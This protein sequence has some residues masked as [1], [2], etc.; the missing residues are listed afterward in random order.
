MTINLN[1]E[2]PAPGPL[3]RVAR[4][5]GWHVPAAGA[6]PATIE[7]WVG[8]VPVGGTLRSVRPD[9]AAAFA[10]RDPRLDCGFVGDLVF[11]R[12]LADGAT[13]DV[14][15]QLTAADGTSVPAWQ[16]SFT[17]AE[18]WSPPAPR[19]RDY[20]L[21]ALL[22]RPGTVSPIHFDDEAE[23][24]WAG[25]LRVP[26]IA[27]VPHF[28][29][30]RA[31]PCVRLLD[32]GATHPYGPRSLALIEAGGTVLDLGCGI[33]SAEQ[34][35]PNV[36]HLDAIHFPNVDVVNTCADLPFHD[37][38]FDT[39]VSQAVFE[40]LPDPAHTAAEILRVLKPGGRVLIETGFMVP[41]HGDPDHY[42]NMTASAMRRVMRGFEIES[43]DVPDYQNPSWGLRMQLEAALLSMQPGVWRKRLELWLAELQQGGAA[44]DRDLGRW[45]REALAA[46]Y[47]VI[48][49]KPA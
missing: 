1:V 40:H 43:I 26:M 5:S 10:D 38:V 2:T 41:L 16:Q 20:D 13:L 36:V 44:L 39:V 14:A 46:G 11:G 18:P 6:A 31:L 3:D 49:R 45:G 48:A 19:P 4:F 37:A 29:P 35:R 30:P 9:V 21:A 17:L 23:T 32:A 12:H 8:G 15:V 33:K 42:F 27:G 28:H 7:L 34:Y 47:C 25:S 22:Q 24:A